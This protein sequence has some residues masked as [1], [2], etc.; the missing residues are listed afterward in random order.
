MPDGQL[1]EPLQPLPLATAEAKIEVVV[2]LQDSVTRLVA[3]N[4]AAYSTGYDAAY[5]GH[6]QLTRRYIAE[7]NKP[8]FK[9]QAI[10]GVVAAAGVGFVVGRVVP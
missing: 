2:T 6:Q 9:L 1:A 4:A 5:T 8:R 3:A 7:L 10:V